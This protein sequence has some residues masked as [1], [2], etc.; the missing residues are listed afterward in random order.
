MDDHVSSMRDQRHPVHRVLRQERVQAVT[1]MAVDEVI[2]LTTPLQG[3]RSFFTPNDYSESSDPLNQ[4]P[5]VVH[6]GCAQRR[7]RALLQQSC[8]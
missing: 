8:R 5:W 6:L 1:V 7:A 4:R 3:R 2:A